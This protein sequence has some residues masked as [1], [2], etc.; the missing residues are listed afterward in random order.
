MSFP[1]LKYVD[2]LNCQEVGEA[3]TSTYKHTLPIFLEAIF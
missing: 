1:N 3:Y 2:P